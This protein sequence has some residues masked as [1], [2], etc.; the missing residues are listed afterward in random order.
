MSAVFK[1]YDNVYRK[2]WYDLE[3]HI[4][5]DVGQIKCRSLSKE[6][7]QLTNTII[8]IYMV[9]PGSALFVITGKISRVVA[10]LLNIL[11]AMQL[12]DLMANFR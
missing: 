10:F 5:K 4:Y 2:L 3:W 9:N 6:S 8:K 1:K 12:R 7:S 11:Y